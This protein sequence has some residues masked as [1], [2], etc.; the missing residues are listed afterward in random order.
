MLVAMVLAVPAAAQSGALTVPRNLAQLTERSADIVRGTVISARVEKHPE[1]TGLDTVVVK[2][3]VQG[4]LQ[5]G[6][7]VIDPLNGHSLVN[8]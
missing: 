3:R 7:V 2:M 8:P 1:L 5:S 6:E 4:G